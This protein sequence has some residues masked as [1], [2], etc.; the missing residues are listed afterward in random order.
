MIAGSIPVKGT[1]IVAEPDKV[2]AAPH[3][4][5]VEEEKHNEA[6]EKLPSEAQKYTLEKNGLWKEGM[7]SRE[8]WV[9][10]R[11]LNAGKIK[12]SQPTP[13]KPYYNGNGD[14]LPFDEKPKRG[15]PRGRANNTR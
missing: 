7:T 2:I 5:E 14:M 4:D 15:R 12:K 9:T 13:S 1:I 10:I 3:T 8:A 11:D 6:G